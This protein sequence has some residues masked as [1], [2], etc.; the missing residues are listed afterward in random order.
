MLDFMKGWFRLQEG[1][2]NMG[3]EGHRGVSDMATEALS[4]PDS[5]SKGNLS[6]PKLDS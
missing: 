4:K 2:P 3:S 6:Q 1:I 5:G